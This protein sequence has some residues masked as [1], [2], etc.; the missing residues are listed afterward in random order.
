[1]VNISE[2]QMQRMINEAEGRAQEILAIAE[3]T[4]NSIEQIAAAIKSAG[5]EDSIRLQLA[6]KY[7]DKLKILARK[8]T[9]VLPVD[10]TDPDSLLRS[11]G[12]GGL[13][14]RDG[15]RPPCRAPLG[16]RGNRPGIAAIQ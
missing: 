15:P 3:A 12:Y 10:I 8:Q 2:G 16:G 11:I 6:G 7:F 14:G 5:G 13:D 1:M 9:R 4:A